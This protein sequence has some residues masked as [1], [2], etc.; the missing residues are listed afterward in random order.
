MEASLVSEPLHLPCIPIR[1]NV[2][3]L[4]LHHDHLSVIHS[5]HTPLSTGSDV[6]LGVEGEP[7]CSVTGRLEG[8]TPDTDHRCLSYWYCYSNTS[9]SSRLVGGYRSL[10]YYHRY[11]WSCR[12]VGG[13]RSC[14]LVGGYR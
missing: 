6:V 3:V 2:G 7:E 4:S 1:P 13:Y 14:S 12:L 8:L 10:S 5:L 11:S 9:S